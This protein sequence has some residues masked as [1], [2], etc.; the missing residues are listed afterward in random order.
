MVAGSEGTDKNGEKVKEGLEGGSWSRERS[1]D[2]INS[3][4]SCVCEE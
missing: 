3:D 4:F 1:R 2:Y